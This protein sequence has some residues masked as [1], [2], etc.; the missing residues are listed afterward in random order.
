MPRA[1]ACRRARRRQA[2]GLDPRILRNSKK[3]SS[4]VISGDHLA[5]SGMQHEALLALL[6]H[7]GDIF[8]PRHDGSL[9]VSPDVTFLH[10]SEMQQLNIIV[11]SGSACAAIERF[12]GSATA[13][14]T[15][16]GLSDADT[17]TSS[18]MSAIT[19]HGHTA[20]NCSSS[21]YRRALAGGLDTLLQQYRCCVLHAR[22][23]LACDPSLP[24][25]ELQ[26]LMH[27]FSAIM[28]RAAMI[29][30][31]VGTDDLKG[32]PLLDYLAEECAHGD[33]GVR[34]M[35]TSLLASCLSV[36]HQQMGSW[37]LHGVLLDP[38]NEFCIS[39][40]ASAS[41]AQNMNVAPAAIA[42]D[43]DVAQ[44]DTIDE[45]DCMAAFEVRVRMLPSFIPIAAARRGL[46]IGRAV[47]IL[48]HSQTP[49]AAR[50]TLE[51]EQRIKRV[52][53]EWAAAS[54]FNRAQYETV[55]ERVRVIVAERL[56]RLLVHFGAFKSHM[57]TLRGLF[58]LGRGDLFHAFIDESRVIMQAPPAAP[59]L[60]DINAAFQ[61]A[62][63]GAILNENSLLS[64]ASVVLD[65]TI[66]LP[67]WNSLNIKYKITWPLGL[68]LTEAVMQR[69]SAIFS[70]LFN[71]KR[72]LTLLARCWY[73]FLRIGHWF[74][75]SHSA[76][77]RSSVDF[78]SVNCCATQHARATAAGS[79][80]GAVTTLLLCDLRARM[81]FLLENLYY[82]IQVQFHF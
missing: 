70:F 33:C 23:R 22:Q 65:G 58:L 8:V 35:A 24:L 69:L 59:A 76:C 77:F 74:I 46:F 44:T 36:F 45:D 43:T 66:P 19:T 40:S 31:R 16:H 55:M 80:E 57:H 47:R 54:S 17:G 32:G 68:L 4:Y 26:S 6:G 18:A 63:S 56:W 49:D 7:S 71:L 12:V 1:L 25:V 62:L 75:V 73:F 14:A 53:N 50:L 48:R 29:A 20:A 5:L 64:R 41:S 78:R 34:E 51:E 10:P 52:V 81:G 15:M 30:A 37:M 9:H 60:N 61:R 79:G 39:H 72:T 21:L 28:A 82:Y 38:F 67:D 27:P 2:Q 42:P 13:A 11:S 3:V